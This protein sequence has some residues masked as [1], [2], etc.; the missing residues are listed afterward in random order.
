MTLS[1][2]QSRLRWLEI[3]GLW[4]EWDPI[5]VLPAEGGP[6]DEY[7]S[8]LGPSLRLLEQGVSLG[9]I[10]KYLEDIVGNHMGLETHGVNYV[11][12]TEFAAKLSS[13]F[14][15]RWSGSHV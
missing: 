10:E 13:W 6:F 14:S 15:S 8:Y 12:S 11:R 9:E 7:D 4:N 5:G 3:R 1:K 2:E